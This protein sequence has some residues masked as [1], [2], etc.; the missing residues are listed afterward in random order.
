MFNNVYIVSATRTAIGNFGGSLKDVSAID[1]GTIVA[2]EALKRA[3]LTGAEID[4]VIFGNVGQYGLNAFLAR[5]VSLNAGIPNAATAQ[6]VNRMCASGLQAVVTG[7]LLLEH[8]EAE[9]VLVGGS[10]N[11]SQYPYCLPQ[12]RWGMRIGVPGDG[13]LDA[14]AVALCEPTT[15]MDQHVAITAENIARRYGMTR[16]QI[17]AYAVDTQERALRAIAEGKF[18]AE[19]VP[20]EVKQKKQTVLFNTDEHPRETTLEQLAC[21]RPILGPDTLITAGNASGIDDAAA[22][23]VLMTGDAARKHGCKPIARLVDF[24]CAGVDPMYMGLGPVEATRKVFQ[25]TGLRAEDFGVVELNEAFAS[26]AMACISELDLDSAC[27]NPN[28]SGIALGHP[29]GA[30]GAIITVKLLYE[31]A[32]RKARYGLATLCIG[33]GQGMSAVFERMGD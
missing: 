20:V 19:I 1:L 30:T 27:T 31:M 28:G 15:G 22:A 13:L 33:G 16:E 21:L 17:D 29:L 32:R 2:K 12:A 8:G 25:K 9:T 10:E 23:L 3:E 5:L 4:E 18:E 7:A 11:M 6:T 24:A 26:Q 14:L